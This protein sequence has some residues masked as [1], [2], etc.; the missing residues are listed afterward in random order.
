MNKGKEPVIDR[1]SVR[2]DGKIF[3]PRSWRWH[4]ELAVHGPYDRP[5]LPLR[6]VS[7]YSV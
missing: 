5:A 6:S 2:P 1:V 3:G 7:T 4:I